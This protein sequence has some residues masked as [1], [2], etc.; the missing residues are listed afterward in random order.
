MSAPRSQIHMLRVMAMRFQDKAPEKLVETV[1]TFAQELEAREADGRTHN[2]QEEKRIERQ[3]TLFAMLPPSDATDRLREAMK[4]RAYDLM[5]NGDGL[6]TDAIL[7]FLP[8]ADT[9]EVFKAWENDQDGD[10]PK[11]R[12]Y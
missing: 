4:R 10:E 5:C 12:F 3:R 2:V 6:A 9:D 7:E 1:R 8:S 11:S